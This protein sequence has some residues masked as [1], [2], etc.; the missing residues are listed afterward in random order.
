MTN[1]KYSSDLY[2]LKKQLWWWNL[3][4]SHWWSGGELQAHPKFVGIWKCVLILAM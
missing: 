1:E 2:D 3:K 4:L